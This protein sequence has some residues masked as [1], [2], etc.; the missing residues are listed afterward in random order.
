M[1]EQLLTFTAMIYRP[2]LDSTGFRTKYN[3]EVLYDIWF[4]KDGY[5]H[6]GVIN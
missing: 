6:Y 2:L 4:I 5:N 3:K 1:P